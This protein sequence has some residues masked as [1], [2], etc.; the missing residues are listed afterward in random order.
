MIRTYI[1]AGV[2]FWAHHGK[3]ALAVKA[4]GILDDANRE[5]VS[6]VFLRLETLP[7]AVFHK[8]RDEVSFYEAFFDGVKEWAAPL[9]AIIQEAHQESCRL[10]LG[11]ID[12][13]HVAAAMLMHADELVTTE[14][15]TK[16][17]HRVTSLKVISLHS[18][19]EI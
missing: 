19:D 13:L 7:K 8:N 10:G 11:T 6:S 18:I 2:L 1:D 17:I 4:M 16:P 3:P 12:A 14:K 5:F 9:D 15:P